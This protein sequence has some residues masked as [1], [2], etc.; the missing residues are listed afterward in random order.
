MCKSSTIA[1]A[2]AVKIMDWTKVPDNELATDID[3][4]DSVGDAK[5][6]EK[7]RRLCAAEEAERCWKEEER[8]QKEAEAEQKWEAKKAKR[9]ASTAAEARKW[10]QTE[11][12]AQASRSWLN[13][14][15]C[16]RC[17]RLRLSCIIPAGVKGWLA[18]GSCAKAKEW[19]KWPEVEMLVSRVG[20]SPQGG[21]H[22]KWAKKV[23]DDNDDDD[24]VILSGQK[25]KRQG[26]SEML[27]EITDRQWGELIQVVST[28]MDVANGHLEQIA[29][30]AQS[31]G[32]KVQRH[33]LLMEGLVGQQQVLLSKL[34]EGVGAAGSGGA[35]EV[36]KDPEELKE[37]QEMQGEGLGGQE[38]TKGVP[39]GVLGD[40]L[41]NAPGNELENGMGV[42]D[43][44][45][46]E[47]Q[48]SQAK[49]KG[50][51]KAL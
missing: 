29:S 47:G 1:G 41:E 27:E 33:H 3:D 24:I 36:V 39:G 30:M 22:R 37:L 32:C 45:G 5:A 14:S 9:G 23:V 10:Q 42:E 17:A 28:H 31:N 21:E 25:T 6:R 16:I 40:E 11:S 19:C 4:M 7:R 50:K 34:V 46:E 44:T 18:C 13:T 26:G 35:G 38:E 49:G 8:Y 51:E 43:G 15:M 12:E 2:P 20:T 48:Q